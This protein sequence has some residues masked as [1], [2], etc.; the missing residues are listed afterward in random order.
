ML[1]DIGIQGIIIDCK[2]MDP[3]GA[4]A[5]RDQIDKLPPRKIK[6]TVS[7]ALVPPLNQEMEPTYDE[8]DYD[9]DEDYGD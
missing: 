1:R 3:Q 7:R 8:D 4:I 9:N 5:L 2:L 6:N